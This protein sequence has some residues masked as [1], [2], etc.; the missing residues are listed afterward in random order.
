MA[1]KRISLADPRFKFD[2]ADPEGFKGGMLRPGPEVGAAMTG[3]SFYELPPGQ[4]LCPYHYEWGEEEWLLVTNGSPTLRDPDGEHQLEPMDLVFFSVGPAG[5]HQVRNDT[6][7]LV[8]CLMFSNVVHP[9]AT[10]YPD[11]DKIGMWTDS[12][13][14][15]SL[16]VRRTAGLKYYDGEV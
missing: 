15:D 14:T 4:A 7:Q 3:V 11:S 13:R 9:T 10:V 6:D 16:L 1:P 8:R 2:P 5:A 12:E